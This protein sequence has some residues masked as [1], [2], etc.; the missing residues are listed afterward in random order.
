MNWYDDIVNKQ[1]MQEQMLAK[2]VE[3]MEVYKRWGFN[4]DEF[5]MH[6]VGLSNVSEW[7]RYYLPLNIYWLEKYWEVTS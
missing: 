4:K 6:L 2:F 1:S 5:K 3:T 7:G